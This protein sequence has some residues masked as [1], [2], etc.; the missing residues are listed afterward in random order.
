MPVDFR[1]AS[2]SWQTQEI[3]IGYWTYDENLQLT[4]WLNIKD[5]YIEW[6]GSD[7]PA[8]VL[9]YGVIKFGQLGPHEEKATIAELEKFVTGTCRDKPIRKWD[10][11]NE[12]AGSTYINHFEVLFFPAS[13]V[14]DLL[15]RSPE[16]VT[17]V[18]RVRTTFRFRPEDNWTMGVDSVHWLFFRFL[19][20][21]SLVDVNVSIHGTEEAL[22]GE[23]AIKRNHLGKRFNKKPSVLKRHRGKF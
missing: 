3:L 11:S 20:R 13:S 7:D 12:F 22:E 1:I 5:I 9:E 18:G 23:G 21:G 14:V 10:A 4:N 19:G 2:H 6:W 17:D 15:K 8:A 16:V